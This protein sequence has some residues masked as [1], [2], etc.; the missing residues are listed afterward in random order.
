MP[1]IFC[2]Y[3]APGSCGDVLQ[4]LLSMNQ[5]WYTGSTFELD[6]RGRYQRR[7][8]ADFKQAFPADDNRWLWRSWTVSDLELLQ[9]WTEKNVMIGTHSLE[10]SQFIKQ[11]LGTDVITLGVTY[12]TELFPAVIKNFC[13]KVAESDHDINRIYQQNSPD[14]Y[15]R[16]KQENLFGARVLKDFLKFGT[17]VPLNQRNQFDIEIKLE[18]ILLGDVSWFAQWLTDHSQQLLQH[19][20]TLQDPLYQVSVSNIDQNYT[21]S[22]GVNSQ[23]TKPDQQPIQLNIYHNTL[24]QHYYPQ[25]PNF[26]NHH[27]F[28]YFLENTKQG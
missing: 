19:W 9:T 20:L 2:L 6:Q 22:L 8:D 3:W 27:E 1:K 23:A 13:T 28:K 25:A 18:S 24:I 12:N 14:A 4:Q 15:S 7:V 17:V 11:Q 16:E 10:Q 5:E 21:R 26:N